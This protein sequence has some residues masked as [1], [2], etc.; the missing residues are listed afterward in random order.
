MFK[1]KLD[2]RQCSNNTLIV[3]DFV[4]RC[5]FLRD[6]HWSIECFLKR[7]SVTDIEVDS[8]IE[9]VNLIDTHIGGKVT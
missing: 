3:G 6:L 2:C 8:M 1:T 5:L 4:G 7:E 9:L